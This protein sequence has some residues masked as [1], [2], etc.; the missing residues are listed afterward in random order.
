MPD[1]LISKLFTP[2][3]VISLAYDES[4]AVAPGSLYELFVNTMILLL[5]TSV[6]VG[7]VLS[8]I[9]LEPG[10][11]ASVIILVAVS[12]SLVTVIL[13]SRLSESAIDAPGRS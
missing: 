3:T 1:L 2:F 7:A 5:P 8:I 10:R 13:N 9:M 11:F 4:D 6:M 12:S